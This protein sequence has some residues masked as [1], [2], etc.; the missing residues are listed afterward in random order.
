MAEDELKA[1][2]KQAR[3]TQHDE[4]QARDAAEQ[5]HTPSPNEE[6]DTAIAQA[7]SIEIGAND[8]EYRAAERCYWQRQLRI[9]FW[10]NVIT[11][12][13]GGVASIGIVVLIATLLENRNEFQASH[14]GPDCFR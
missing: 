5:H 4:R 3:E 6:R 9:G 7:G 14:K 11:A 13:A 12:I 8:R 1:V 2:E 10:L